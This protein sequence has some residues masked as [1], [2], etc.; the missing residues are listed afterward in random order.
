MHA[1]TVHL[2]VGTG[3]TVETFVL[4]FCQFCSQNSFPKMIS[5]NVSTY[6]AAAEELQ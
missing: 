5:D 3:L 4:G 6:F 1:L 2:E